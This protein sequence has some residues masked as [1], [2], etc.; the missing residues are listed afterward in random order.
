MPDRYCVKSNPFLTLGDFSSEQNL[1]E[2]TLKISKNK[3]TNS[4][5]C[6]M[7]G[8]GIIIRSTFCTNTEPEGGSSNFHREVVN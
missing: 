7:N 1:V 5:H 3:M 6:G 2:S 4:C 8:K